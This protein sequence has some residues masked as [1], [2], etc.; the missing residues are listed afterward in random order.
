MCYIHVQNGYGRG[1]IVCLTHTHI[2]TQ[3]AH[4]HSEGLTVHVCVCVC[5]CTLAYMLA[6][7]HAR[8]PP[9]IHTRMQTNQRVYA[10][11]TWVWAMELKVTLTLLWGRR[12]LIG[13]LCYMRVCVLC[14]CVIYILFLIIRCHMHVCICV[15]KYIYS[16]TW[17]GGVMR[18]STQTRCAFV[19]MCA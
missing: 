6:Y 2:R 9:Y 16:Y 8:I 7:I 12:F 3:R 19:Q 1:N 17:R 14:S 4:A 10:G 13:M 11:T 15:Y 18:L 5:V